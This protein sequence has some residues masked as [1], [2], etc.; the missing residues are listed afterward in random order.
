[1]L[2]AAKRIKGYKITAVDGD[3]G[4]AADWLFDGRSWAVRYLE[5]D[6]GGWLS[7]RR[8]L[9]APAV[10][11]DIDSD[12]KTIAVGLNREQVRNSPALDP[13]A[14]I[15][16]QHEI[17]LQQYYSWPAYW[18]AASGPWQASAMGPGPAPVD[19]GGGGAAMSR[20][21]AD[22]GMRSVNDATACAVT[23][24][25]GEIGHIDDLIL[26]DEAWRVRYLLVDTRTWWPGKYVIVGTEWVPNGIWR[27]DA[28]SVELTREAVRQSPPFDPSKPVNREY[29]EKLYE[30]YKRTGH[31][32]GEGST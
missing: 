32:P 27:E 18:T 14:P 23:A 15:S 6:T 24:L 20:A 13:G 5:V 8:V 25:D 22:A 16:R 17:D 19:M 9:L 10:I 12:E 28:V 4:K 31:P 1:V 29:E 30:Y 11:G 3:I 7:K 2:R 26:D 21:P